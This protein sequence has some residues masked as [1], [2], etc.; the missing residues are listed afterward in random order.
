MSVDLWLR[1]RACPWSACSFVLVD[2]TSED[3]AAFDPAYRKADQVCAIGGSSKIE[4]SVW[5]VPVV[6]GRVL[7]QHNPQVPLPE[8]QHPVGALGTPRSPKSIRRLRACWATQA[9]SGLAVTPRT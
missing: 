2:Q 1:S 6:M 8:D 3:L 7:G 4:R 5:P 9:P